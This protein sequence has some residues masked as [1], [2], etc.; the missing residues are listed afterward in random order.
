MTV[1]VFAA[2]TCL[3]VLSKLGGC[4]TVEGVGEDTRDVGRGI[5]GAARGA[6]NP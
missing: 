5:S 4:H 3:I 1:W 2:M 6:D